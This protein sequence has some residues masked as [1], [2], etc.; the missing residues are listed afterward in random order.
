MLHTNHLGIDFVD[1]YVA[2]RVTYSSIADVFGFY[3]PKTRGATRPSYP[4]KRQA[5]A[6][7]SAP[8][9]VTTRPTLGLGQD[10]TGGHL[11]CGIG[12]HHHLMLGATDTIHHYNGTCSYP[13]H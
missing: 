6:I 11:V 13:L 2:H 4:L 1:C 12:I 3:I 9:R 5:V 8:K 10:C 7:V